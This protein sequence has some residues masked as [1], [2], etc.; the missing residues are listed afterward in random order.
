MG[1]MNN[2]RGL[3][4]QIKGSRPR[5]RVGSSAAVKVGEET[6]KFCELSVVYPLYDFHPG[7][8]GNTRTG[9]RFRR[10]LARRIKLMD[11]R[12]TRHQITQ[13]LSSLT[14]TAD[15]IA[16]V[17]EDITAPLSP[18]DMPPLECVH[19]DSV[20]AFATNWNAVEMLGIQH[21]PNYE[22]AAIMDDDRHDEAGLLPIFSPRILP[23]DTSD[24]PD[25]ASRGVLDPDTQDDQEADLRQNGLHF[26]S[27]LSCS[28]MVYGPPHHK[29]AHKSSRAA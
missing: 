15:P 19:C 21:L 6:I 29:Y 14:V 28:G 9:R 18:L 3:L 25:Y 20:G 22:A 24:L 13:E 7:T 10:K 12:T 27:K 4:E 5:Q 17:V 2:R 16:A 23:E 26:G 11:R 8:G 1:S